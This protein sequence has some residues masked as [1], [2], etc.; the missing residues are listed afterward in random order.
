MSNG[1]VESALQLAIFEGR[2]PETFHTKRASAA[3]EV[4]WVE[5]LPRSR[6]KI[7]RAYDRVSDI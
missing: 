1:F 5:S 3:R 7:P 2:C 4:S 6:C